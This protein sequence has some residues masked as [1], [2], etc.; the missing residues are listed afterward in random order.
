MAILSG[1]GTKSPWTN[2][3]GGNKVI[4]M[5]KDRLQNEPSIISLG[6][7]IRYWQQRIRW[8]SSREVAGVLV[9]WL[10]LQVVVL[11]AGC[12]T[13][14][15]VIQLKPEP[16]ALNA[17]YMLS[18]EEITN[19]TKQAILGDGDAAYRLYNFYD[20]VHYD[21]DAALRWLEVAAK[22]G[23]TVAQYN[24]GMD[25]DG[26]IYPD[27]TDIKRAEYWFQRAATGGDANAARKLRE[28]QDNLIYEK[29]P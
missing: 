19:L 12:R 20:M 6:G 8:L 2:S 13:K 7:T 23:N 17:D 18:N 10:L 28:L 21:R 3:Q 14:P 24:M 26:E 25:Y 9:M 16:I 4:F 11:L 1:L 15:E 22:S 29:K 5:K 27:L